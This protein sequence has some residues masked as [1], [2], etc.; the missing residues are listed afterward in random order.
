MYCEERVISAVVVYK[1]KS[2]SGPNPNEP[3]RY[4]H[5]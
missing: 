5:C 3:P 2:G 1:A 4:H